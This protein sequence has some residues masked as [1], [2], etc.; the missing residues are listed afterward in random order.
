[1]PGGTG[2]IGGPDGGILGAVGIEFGN[3]TAMTVDGMTAEAGA[4]V[5]AATGA[6]GASANS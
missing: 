1:M 6:G 2:G 3:G 4:S 5:V